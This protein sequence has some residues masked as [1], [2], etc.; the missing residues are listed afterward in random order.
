MYEYFQFHSPTKIVF[1]IGVSGDFTS[2]I[3]TL[4]IKKTLVV[5]DKGI[6]KAGL[7][8]PIVKVLENAGVEVIGPYLNISKDAPIASINKLARSGR[9]RGAD[10]ILALGGGSV[11]DSAKAANI[12]I[13]H[14][15]DLLEDYAGVQ[16]IPSALKP[17][18]V[19]PTTAGTGSEVTSAAVVLDEKA[20]VK[21]SFIDDFLKPTLAILDPSLTLKMPSHLTS[22]TGVDAFSHALEAFTSPMKSPIS[23]GL[24][25]EALRLIKDHLVKVLDTPDDIEGRSEMMTAATIAGMAFDNAMVGIIHGIAHTLGGLTG[26]SHGESI[27][28]A[29]PVGILYN[30]EVAKNRYAEVARRLGI[31]AP[32]T[33]DDT[34]S[35][36]FWVWIEKWRAAVTERSHLA[37]TFKE[38]G[39]TEE[40][41]IKVA[42]GAVNDGTSFYNPREVVEEDLLPFLMGNLE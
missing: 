17:L 2:E 42:R 25:I 39:V 24:A 15:G 9:E 34:A 18:I 31:A 26:L 27:F 38:K 1:G 22:A 23:D 3:Q 19:I 16:T 11:I 7:I 21:H 28:L 41:L 32:K 36:L 12:L 10:S 37:M 33:S 8:E 29:L 6:A 5:S 30:M 40:I 4:R 13:T 14:G 35:K 20:G